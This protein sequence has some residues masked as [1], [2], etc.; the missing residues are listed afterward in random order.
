MVMVMSISY[1]PLHS[2]LLVLLQPSNGVSIAS[3]KQLLLLR[4]PLYLQATSNISTL[5]AAKIN[6][7]SSE[8]SRQVMALSSGSSTTLEPI[9]ALHIVLLVA[10]SLVK[11]SLS[12]NIQMILRQPST[13]E[14]L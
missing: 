2:A 5:M 11:K 1:S 3:I 8:C 4:S 12:L 14:L 13:Q 9:Q 6:E 10:L 7:I